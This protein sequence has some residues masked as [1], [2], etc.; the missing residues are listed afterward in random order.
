MFCDDHDPMT[1]VEA[2]AKRKT[3]AP[4]EYDFLCIQMA[5]PTLRARIEKACL[6]ILD[7]DGEKANPCIIAAAAAGF[8]K[9]GDHDIVAAVLELP[10]DPV[11]PAGGMTLGRTLLLGRTGDLRGAPVVRKMWEDAIPRAAARE[12]KRRSLA[13]WSAWRQVAAEALGKL[14]R[15][16]DATFLDAQAAATKDKYVAKACRAGAAAIRARQP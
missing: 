10:E 7:R 12:K 14:G 4:G 2:F 15:P 8:A 5:A 3:S 16:D 9:L 13:G 11:E 1:A 6:A